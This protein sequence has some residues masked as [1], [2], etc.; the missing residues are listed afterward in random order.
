MRIF[1]AKRFKKKK[2]TKN[3]K[4]IKNKDKFIQFI[5]LFYPSILI[6][7]HTF[8]Q[9]KIS[10]FLTFNNFK[11][12]IQTNTHVPYE[13]NNCATLLLTNVT[14]FNFI[15]SRKEYIFSLSLSLYLEFASHF[16]NQPPP[17]P[18]HSNESRNE[19]KLFRTK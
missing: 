5:P 14:N 3:T 1:F 16:F 11:K 2:W 10:L 15:I 6:V 4:Y 18:P 9:N 8:E 7:H 13:I 17:P 12:K 19:I